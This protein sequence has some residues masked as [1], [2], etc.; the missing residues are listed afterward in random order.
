MNRIS[1]TA[2]FF[3]AVFLYSGSLFCK[4]VTTKAKKDQSSTANSKRP[5]IDASVTKTEQ[6]I[7]DTELDSAKKNK[8]SRACSTSKF[9]LPID[10]QMAY[11]LRGGF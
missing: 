4:L 11:P 6:N 8:P 3:A 1:K 7:C 2:L 5:L 9:V 10:T